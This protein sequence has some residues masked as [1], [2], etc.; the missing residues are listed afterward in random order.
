MFLKNN[1]R[2]ALDYVLERSK[3]KF[4]AEHM[5]PLRERLSKN[6]N[7]YLFLVPATPG[8]NHITNF[9]A[10]KLLGN[11]EIACA[12]G[13]ARQRN[14]QI[15]NQKASRLSKMIKNH[16]NATDY[17]CAQGLAFQG[18][19]ESKLSSNRGNFLDL[20]EFLGS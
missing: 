6:L 8:K 17:L 20:I 5:V 16:T 19:N 11:V 15:H 4:P 7:A 2:R 3:P 1:V 18:H 9:I 13:E 12:L 10:Y 14:I